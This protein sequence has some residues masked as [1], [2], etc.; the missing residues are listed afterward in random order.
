[1]V[2]ARQGARAV[3]KRRAKRWK[4]IPATVMIVAGIGLVLYPMGTLLYTWLQQRDLRGQLETSHPQ[5]AS[6]SLATLEH[7]LL[8]Q[9]ATTTTSSPAEPSSQPDPA[10]AAEAQKAAEEAA[11]QARLQAFAKAATTFKQSVSGK[12]GEP[13]GRIVVSSIGV[14]VVM[15][16]GTR[17]GDLKEGPG[18]WPETPFPGQ[19]G[20][21][22]V[23][24][25][26]TT[27]GAP[28]FKLNKLKK[29]DEIDLLLPYAI[30]RYTVARVVVVLPDQ[31]ETVGQQGREQ[32]SLVA[33]HPLYSASHRIVAQADLTGFELVIP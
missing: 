24:G 11:R 3:S 31:V 10:A 5:L 20:N 23:S 8:E 16:E 29:G 6:A 28:F 15:V 27:F 22:V 1:M 32:V 9:T 18:H 21:F 14:D 4:T 25:H 2:A 33:C 13:I 30:A 7:S 12:T 17:T 26:R 19:G